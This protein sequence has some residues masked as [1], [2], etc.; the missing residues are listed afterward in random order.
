MGIGKPMAA[1]I[2]VLLVTWFAGGFNVWAEE[3]ARLKIRGMTCAT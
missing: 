1:I 2:A 3:Q